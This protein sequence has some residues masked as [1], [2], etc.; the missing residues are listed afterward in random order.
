MEEERK[1]QVQKKYQLNQATFRTDNSLLRFKISRALSAMQSLTRL[2]IA[3]LIRLKIIT[4]SKLHV[5]IMICALENARNQLLSSKS[6]LIQ[7][8]I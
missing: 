7:N 1:K 3:L 6:G 2:A 5:V 4:K 8:K